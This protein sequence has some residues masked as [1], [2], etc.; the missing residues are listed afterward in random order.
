MPLPFTLDVSATRSRTACNI[1]VRI[2]SIGRQSDPI[3]NQ[4]TH[5]AH[6]DGRDKHRVFLAYY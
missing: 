6:M 1:K 5:Y 3:N 4:E 2:I